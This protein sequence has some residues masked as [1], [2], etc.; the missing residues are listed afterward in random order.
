[1]DVLLQDFRYAARKLV[2]AP[3]FTLAAVATL[4]IGI[5]ATTAIFSTVNATLLRPLPYPQSENLFALRT[6]YTDGRVTTGLVAA[7][8][9]SRLGDAKGSIE[10]AVAMSSA[11]FDATLLRESAPPLKANIHFVGDGFFELFGLPM[12]LGSAFTHEQ[13]TPIPQRGAAVKGTDLRRLSSCRITPGRTLRQRSRSIVGST[14][15]FAEFN[16]D[17][18]SA[19]ARAIS[20]S[21]KVSTSGLTRASIRATSATASRPP[22]ASRP[23]RP[24]SASAAKWAS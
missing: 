20:T 18:S 6:R 24:S 15:R 4:A 14:I 22:S 2:N 19:S 9:A 12:T 16:V 21:R 11:P 10:R 5:G 13:Q 3:V 7:V 17:G 1:M 23:A 8:E